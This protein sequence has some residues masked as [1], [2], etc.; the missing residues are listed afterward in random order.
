[1]SSPPD[2]PEPQAHLNQHESHLA[3]KTSKFKL[4][5]IQN[6]ISNPQLLISAIVIVLIFV[7]GVTF[8]GTKI[9]DAATANRLV[10]CGTTVENQGSASATVS[11]N[12]ASS[13]TSG[14]KLNTCFEK[15]FR[16]CLPA[17]VIYTYPNNVPIVGGVESKYTI[18][19]KVSGG[20]SMQSVYLKYPLATTF[21]NKT[22]TC[23]YN[24][25]ATNS[26]GAEDALTN[27]GFKNCSGPL[28]QLLTPSANSQLETNAT[29]QTTA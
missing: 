23:T 21:Q 12:S 27:N 11:T 7:A 25:Q 20:C 4:P 15:R 16:A 18:I 26:F 13:S 14:E 28:Y 29:T 3:K 10:N 9:Y 5:P 6:I 24:N 1:M 17:T 22:L 2:A 19:G 8:G